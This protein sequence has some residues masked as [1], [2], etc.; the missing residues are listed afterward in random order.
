MVEKTPFSSMK[1]V[2]FTIKKSELFN[3]FLLLF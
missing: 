3:D 2:Y 1:V